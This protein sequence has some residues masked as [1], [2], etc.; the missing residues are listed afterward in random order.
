ME[1][2]PHQRKLTGDEKAYEKMLHVICHQEHGNEDNEVPQ[3]TC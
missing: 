1:C 3:R 2:T